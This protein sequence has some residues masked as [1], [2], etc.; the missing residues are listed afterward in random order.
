MLDVGQG[1]Y[2]NGTCPTNVQ[3]DYS[4][5]ANGEFLILETGATNT[6]FHDREQF[7]EYET[8][9]LLVNSFV[10][11]VDGKPQTVVGTGV[12]CVRVKNG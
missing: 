7:S 9:V 1:S 12:V 3:A 11:T 2:V 4:L 10:N 8:G 5:G 6:V